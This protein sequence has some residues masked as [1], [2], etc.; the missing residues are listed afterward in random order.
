VSFIALPRPSSFPQPPTSDVFLRKHQLA[1]TCSAC[2]PAPVAGAR[3]S[4]APSR[5]WRHSF[6]AS[7]LA[8]GPQRDRCRAIPEFHPR[9]HRPGT[10]GKAEGAPIALR[11]HPIG[12]RNLPLIDDENW[13]GDLSQREREIR[14]V[15]CFEPCLLHDRCDEGP[16]LLGALLW[17]FHTRHARRSSV[18][19]RD[20]ADQFFTAR[21]M[22]ILMASG[23]PIVQSWCAT[24]S[25]GQ[26]K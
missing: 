5:V 13:A 19:G 20:V 2:L 7:A 15:Q 4:C 17:R 21:L 26:S 8:L 1:F 11:R 10:H 3:L 12:C 22:M 16:L 9:N 18:G 14:L 6:S 24:P 25:T 23:A